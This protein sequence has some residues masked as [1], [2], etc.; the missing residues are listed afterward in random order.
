MSYR[1]ARFL[2]KDKSL[3]TPREEA[4]VRAYIA[5]G[6]IAAAAKAQGVTYQTACNQM[7]AVR[8]K[9]GANTT[10]HAAQKW[11]ERERKC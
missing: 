8:H 7:V 2:A 5:H 10:K 6:S 11:Q 4:M 3:L 9:L 1:P